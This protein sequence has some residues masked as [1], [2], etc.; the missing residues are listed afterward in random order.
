MGYIGKGLWGVECTLAVVGTGGPRIS[1]TGLGSVICTPGPPLPP[2]PPP[3]LPPPPG[4][5]P[6]GEAALRPV[7][8]RPPPP[9]PP[10]SWDVRAVH[11]EDLA[12]LAANEKLGG[13]GAPAQRGGLVGHLDVADGLEGSLLLLEVEEEDG[14]VLGGGGEE[15]VVA[16]EGNDRHLVLVGF[17]AVVHLPLVRAPGEHAHHAVLEADHH[18]CH[19]P[20]SGC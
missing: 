18:L 2:P 3:P 10:P 16:G 9:R 12:V 6:P 19:E 17:E 7:R 4:P 11:L 8:P 5:P 1:A 15:L 14:L 20:N 13:V